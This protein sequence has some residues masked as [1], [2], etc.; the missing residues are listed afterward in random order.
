MC[1]SVLI[2]TYNGFNFHFVIIK[3]YDIILQSIQFFEN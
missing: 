2:E 1:L 3:N